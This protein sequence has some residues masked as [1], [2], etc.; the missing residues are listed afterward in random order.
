MKKTLLGFILLCLLVI[1]T[2]A[3]NPYSQDKIST[4]GVVTGKI[5]DQVSKSPLEYATISLYQA[6]DSSLVTGTTTDKKLFSL[7][8]EKEN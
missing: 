2:N 1:Q 7:I 6:K 4:Q 3:Q 8:N 5:V